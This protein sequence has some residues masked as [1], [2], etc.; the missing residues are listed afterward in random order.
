[1]GMHTDFHF[2]LE[3]NLNR[4]REKYEIHLQI[5][6]CRFA[7]MTIMGDKQIPVCRTDVLTV[8]SQFALS[9]DKTRILVYW[10]VPLLAQGHKMFP[11]TGK[12]RKMGLKY[13]L[14]RAK[15]AKTVVKCSLTRRKTIK[16]S[17][18]RTRAKIN[19]SKALL[20][21]STEFKTCQ[22]M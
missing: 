7:S 4:L 16:C 20:T 6:V 15:A 13:S 19:G 11:D 2:V 8:K 18:T 14:L 21:R 17:L 5:P 12:S 3:C 1:M 22:G 9:I 10:Y